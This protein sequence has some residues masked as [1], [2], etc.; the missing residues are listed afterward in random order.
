VNKYTAVLLLVMVDGL[1]C[2]DRAGYHFEKQLQS[3]RRPGKGV[4]PDRE[5]DLPKKENNLRMTNR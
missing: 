2:F 4:I 5:N 1:S 3:Y